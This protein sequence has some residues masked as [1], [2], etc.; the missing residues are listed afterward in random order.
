MSRA[1]QD[2][3]VGCAHRMM[4]FCRGMLHAV[5]RGFAIFLASF[6][7]LNLVGEFSHS[8]FDASLWWIDLRA[9]PGPLSSTLLIL[10]AAILIDSVFRPD[11]PRWQKRLRSVVVLAVCLCVLRDAIVFWQLLR[12]HVIHAGFPIPFSLLIAAGLL[13]ILLDFHLPEIGH[14]P[15]TDAS[16]SSPPRG[17]MW[18]LTMGSAAACLVVFPLLQM[19]CFGWTDYR[20]KG[21]IA[22]VFGC[23]V[24]ANGTLSAALADRVRSGCELYHDGLVDHLMMSGGPGRGAVHETHAMREFAV[25]HGVPRDRILIDEFGLSTDETVT[26][27]VPVMR[28]RGFDRVLAVSHFYHLP[29]IKL[30]YRRAG[31][32]VFTVPATQAFRIPHQ[33][34]LL[35]REVAALWAYYLRPLTGI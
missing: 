32:D 17:R 10:V 30:A 16:D 15:E 7:L 33:E 1:G 21:D 2:A 12:T 25:Q 6:T 13:L 29:R 26:G 8:G 28:R 4:R 20:R 5:A 24:Y 31:L 14:L 35:A 3:G 23:K 22:V 34:L 27:T 11:V 18:V 19:Y 9:V